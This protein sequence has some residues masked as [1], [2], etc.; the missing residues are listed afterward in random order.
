MVVL[1]S[2]CKIK[3]Y[4][5]DQGTQVACISEISCN[6]HFPLQR[7]SS[8]YISTSYSQLWDVIFFSCLLGNPIFL[9]N[10]IVVGAA[11]IS[12]YMIPSMKGG[13]SSLVSKSILFPDHQ[14]LKR[15]LL[16]YRALGVNAVCHLFL[17][18]FP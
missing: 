1:G 2:D 18:T 14:S 3:F 5:R 12:F 7:D 13:H 11:H 6:I 16:R 17:W 8:F 9:L 10:H 15:I 4:L